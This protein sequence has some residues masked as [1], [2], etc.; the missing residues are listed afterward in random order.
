MRM[1]W[2]LFV[3]FLLPWI[4]STFRIPVESQATIVFTYAMI[5]G[6]SAEPRKPDMTIVISDS[7]ETEILIY[8]A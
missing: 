7:S 8:S 3:S 4:C 2:A 1:M 5:I 6:K